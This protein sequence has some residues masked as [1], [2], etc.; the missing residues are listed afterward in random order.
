[1]PVMQAAPVPAAGI[2]IL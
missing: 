1:M 2:F